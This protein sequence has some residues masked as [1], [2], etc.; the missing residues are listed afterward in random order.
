MLPKSTFLDSRY[1]SAGLA[2]EDGENSEQSAE[3]ESVRR[4][5]TDEMIGVS[6]KMTEAMD[7]ADDRTATNTPIAAMARGEESGSGVKRS[8]L[9]LGN[10]LKQVRQCIRTYHK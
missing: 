2:G 7:G 1:R 3:T 9:S 10:L 8:R 6:V 5:L 4:K